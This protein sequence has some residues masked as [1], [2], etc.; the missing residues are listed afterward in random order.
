M[1]SSNLSAEVLTEYVGDLR[2]EIDTEAKTA[3]VVRWVDT[4]Y[5]GDIVVPERI[6]ASNKKIYSVVKIGERVFQECGDL[7]SITIANSVTSIGDYC[8][9]FCSRLSKVI[10]PDNLEAIP[11]MCFYQCIKLSNIKIPN[12][13]KYFGNFSFA[14]TVLKTIEIPSSVIAIGVGAFECTELTTIEIPNTVEAIS[15]NCFR[16]CRKLVSVL[17]PGS[18]PFIPISCFEDCDRLMLVEIKDGVTRVESSCFKNC[19]CLRSVRF[20]STLEYIGPNIFEGCRWFDYVTFY[21]KCPEGI[22]EANMPNTTRISVPEEYKQDY[23]S[24]LGNDYTKIY[25]FAIAK[26][27]KCEKPSITFSNGKLHFDCSIPKASYHYTITSPDM[28]EEGTSDGVVNLYA[29][30]LITASA[31]AAGYDYSDH[32]TATLYWINANLETSTN[33]NQAKTRGIIATSNNGIVT[34]SGLDE[35]ERVYFYSVDGKR[36][37]TVQAIDGKASQAVSESIVIAKIGNQS[38]KIIAK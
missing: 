21:G 5:A 28:E 20:P 19:L 9:Y 37:G 23:K 7:T 12:T 10:L 26:Y 25:T 2:Y 3:T 13:V 1:A 27:D 18:V 36:L 38:I 33:I 32:V 22:V 29:S 16:Y 31:Y 8:F 15:S 34:L 6:R 30:Y 4:K 17:W 11:G 35:G 14:Y 24:K